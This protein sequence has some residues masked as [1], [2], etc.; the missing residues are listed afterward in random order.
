MSL[1]DFESMAQIA[2][3]VA[4]VVAV[5]IGGSWSYMLFVSRRQK[6]PRANIEHQVICRPVIKGKLL[7][8][9]D[10]TITNSSEVL[11]SLISW[12]I[13]AKQMLPPCSELLRYLTPDI[14]NHLDNGIQII[15]WQTIALREDRWKKG[16]FE[17]E[18]GEQHQIHTD[19]LI[20]SDIQ[21]LLLESYFRNI[22]KRGKRIGWSLI[23][24]HDLQA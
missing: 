12:E 20:N 10:V 15:E 21:T 8:S 16:Q 23:T 22:E 6:F 18:P 7:L 11:L 14:L 13:I 5:L 3:A 9:V 4:T 1:S 17:I 19:F 2:Q 24:T